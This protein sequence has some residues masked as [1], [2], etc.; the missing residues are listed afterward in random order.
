M[1]A[2]LLLADPSWAELFMKTV[3]F[4]IIYKQTKQSQRQNEKFPEPDESTVKHS[5]F[6]ARFFTRVTDELFVID[7]T[8]PTNCQTEDNISELS[9]LLG[10]DLNKY[11]LCSTEIFTSCTF[12]C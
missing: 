1:R 7:R 9:L 5:V 11:L 4:Q 10:M 8:D 3:L 6:P 2:D 12:K